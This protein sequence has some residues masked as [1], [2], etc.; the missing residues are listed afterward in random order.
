M[1]QISIP[2][3]LDTKEESNLF[4]RAVWARLRTDFGK[5]AW[6]FAPMTSRE[7]RITNLGYIDIGTKNTIEVSVQY[8]KRGTV[9]HLMLAD[10]NQK[11]LPENLQVA[12]KETLSTY[13]KGRSRHVMQ[14]TLRFHYPM[15]HYE[16]PFIQIVPTN[17]GVNMLRMIIMAYDLDDAKFIFKKKI[18]AVVDILIACLWT[19][20]TYGIEEGAEEERVNSN[21]FIENVEPSQNDEV[22]V[23]KGQYYLSEKTLIFMNSVV[24]ED[25]IPD[26]MVRFLSAARLYKNGIRLED[27][28]RRAIN[29]GIDYTEMVMVAFMSSLEVLAANGDVNTETCDACNQLKYSIAKRVRELAGKVS[30]NNKYFTKLVNDFYQNRSK[31][32]HE[33]VFSS[34]DSY[35][36]VTI[37]QVNESEDGVERQ[38]HFFSGLR[39]NV[40]KVFQWVI[41]N[42]LNTK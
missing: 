16:L 10:T 30:D 11:A 9:Q 6:N 7:K 14:T 22:G 36:G 15:V 29:Q 20:V 34:T 2:V 39:F 8:K 1:H 24:E 4:L 5:C 41:Q 19:D 12:L 35:S 31:F 23:F 42:S 17:N 40:G 37:P 32:L 3:N 21:T 28:S 33:G 38:V 27:V 25:I 18:N 13:K 26:N